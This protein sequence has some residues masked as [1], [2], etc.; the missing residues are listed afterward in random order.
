MFIYA[1]NV[2][3]IIRKTNLKTDY[4]IIDSLKTLF[5][6]FFSIK[7]GVLILISISKPIV[8]CCGSFQK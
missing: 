1:I 8:I 5:R 2:F 4:S 3:S 7:C 6:V